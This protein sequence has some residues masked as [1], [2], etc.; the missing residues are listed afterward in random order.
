MEH[1]TSTSGALQN[2]RERWR[3]PGSLKLIY[4]NQKDFKGLLVQ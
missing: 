1:E 4:C 2:T 3:L